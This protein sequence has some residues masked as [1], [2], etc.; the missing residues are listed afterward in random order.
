[1]LFFFVNGLFGQ[2]IHF[3]KPYYFSG[4]HIFYSIHLTG[5][6]GND[7]S[8]SISFY[9]ELELVSRHH[10]MSENGTINGYV[11]LPFSLTSGQYVFQVHLF[12]NVSL[13]PVLV[14]SGNIPVYNDNELSTLQSLERIKDSAF[15]TENADLTLNCDRETSEQRSELTCTL[16]GGDDGIYS[17]AIKEEAIP[18]NMKKVGGLSIGDISQFS[19]K[20]PFYG[21][22]IYEKENQIN[23]PLILS[24]LP[25][26]MNF[27]GALANDEGNFAVPLPKVNGNHSIQFYDHLNLNFNIEKVELPGPEKSA[28]HDLKIS[29]NILDHLRDYQKRKLIYQLYNQLDQTIPLDPDSSFTQKIKPDYDLWVADYNVKGSLGDLFLEVFTPLKFRKDR[30]GQY[31]ASMMYEQG[32]LTKFYDKKT[33][34]IV[35]GQLTTDDHFIG[36]LAIHLVESMKIYSNYDKLKE[37]FGKGALRG[38]V[39][40]EMKDPSYVMPDHVKLPKFEMIGYQKPLSYPLSFVED[41]EEIIQLRPLIYWNPHFNKS[42]ESSFTFRTSD[43]P[44]RY[45]V[46]I[47][48]V[49]SMGN[50]IYRSRLIKVVAKEGQ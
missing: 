26:D 41:N 12:R 49:D 38:V 4:E 7:V 17:I 14:Y 30:S 3:D 44:G 25:D 19:D 6:E 13:D 11:K 10:H 43:D 35:N 39:E 5:Q 20:I 28:F 47:V 37:N 24:I 1:M 40:I 16:E 15:Y 9:S 36:S 32:R 33:L 18:L 27:T 21:K 45:R 22:R 50:S 31:I 23:N 29:D 42:K 34:F 8:A 2:V 48:G 46:E